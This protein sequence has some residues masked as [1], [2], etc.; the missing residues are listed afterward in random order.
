MAEPIDKELLAILVCPLTHKPLVQQGDWLV[1]EE[2]V[3]PRRYPIRDGIPVMLIDESEI[4]TE[5]GDWRLA[6]STGD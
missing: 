2:A 4:R 5:A 1:A 6:E 3:P